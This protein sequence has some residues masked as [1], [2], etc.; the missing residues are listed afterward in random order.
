MCFI[1]AGISGATLIRPQLERLRDRAA[2]GLVD[3]LYIL[4]PDRL[5][6]K[7]AHQALLMEE[8]S[9]CGVQVVFLNHE[10]GATPEESLLLQMQGM[11]SEYERAKITE[12]NR[13]GKLHSAKR[14]SVN[15]L[16]TAPYG[17]RYIRKQLDGTPAQYVIELP[18]AA[19]VKTIFQW[20]GMDR[21]SIGEVVRRLA[22]AGT[23]TASGKLY[24]D[25]SVVWGILRN[26]AYMGRAA[27]GKTQ[28]RDRL[29]HVRV[30]TQ[31]HSTDVPRRAY[32]TTPTDPQQWIEIPVPAIVSEAMFH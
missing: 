21:L 15:V 25:R 27:F 1:D 13:R 18:Q 3:R 26:P 20:I 28:S 8:F 2:L 7:Y 17:Y 4:S 22:E 6:R 9:A 10:I 5:A 32:S 30:R 31:R 19:T 16:S 23:V 14:G 24:W 12:R 11:I 29:P